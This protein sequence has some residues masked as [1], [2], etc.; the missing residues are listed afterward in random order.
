MNRTLNAILLILLCGSMQSMVAQLPAYYEPYRIY[1]D[2]QELFAKEKYGAA[3]EKFE[4]Y[5]L[6]GYDRDDQS[7]EQNAN[8]RF[9]QAVS[10]YYLDRFDTE[11][12]LQSFIAGFPQNSKWA[13]A[14]YFLGR[15]YFEQKEFSEAIP[16]LELFSKTP[17][18]D[19]EMAQEAGFLVAYGH[20]M[21]GDYTK[22]QPIFAEVKKSQSPFAEDARY[23]DAIILYQNGDYGKAYDALK[24][25][26]Y[27]KK[28]RDEIR[29]YLA[30][31]MLKLK[32]YGELNILADEL[33]SD[34]RAQRKDAEIYFIV[35]N[36]SYERDDYAKAAKYF[37]DYETNGG[38]LSRH[39]YF[40]YAQAHY[41]LEQ[42]P[43]A[44][45]LYKK[46]LDTK[47]DSLTQIAL[48]LFRL[49]LSQSR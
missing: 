17:G 42:Y 44:V 36:A 13:E 20:F 15:Y 14:H 3:Y 46:A 25:L 32:K 38:Q 24:E 48:L 34:P 26:E 12:L 19:D 33:A 11:P 23:Y 5:L 7:N 47:R 41:N 30:N 28:Y 2:A 4:A 6:A 31:V 40:R 16:H 45:P 43:S 22:S 39:G 35:G 37:R 18:T 49:L 21:N 8:A 27:S 9:Y 10:A 29:V 1:K